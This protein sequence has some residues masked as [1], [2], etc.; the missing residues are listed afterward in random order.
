MATFAEQA[1]AVST[2][3]GYRS[4]FHIFVTW[5]EASGVPSLPASPAD[6]A[7]FLSAEAMRGV[8]V[9]TLGCR[10]AAIR[11]AHKLA[12]FEPPTASEVVRTVLAGIR[13]TVGTAVDRKAAATHDVLGAMLRHIPDTLTGRRD[14]ALLTLGFAA[15]L[16]RSELVALR[17]ED[18]QPDDDGFRVLIRKS[19]TDQEGA[20]QRIAVPHGSHLRPVGAVYDWLATAQISEGPI[21]RPIAKG[22]R[23]LATALTDRSVATI[24]KR[25]AS[26]AGLDPA[27][28][29]GHSLRSGF[30]TSAAKTGALVHKMQAVSR[31]KTVNILFDYVRDADAYKDHAGKEFL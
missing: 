19:K 18:L 24:V 29:S 10:I 11:Y 20:G 14:R 9:S 21:F 28:Y 23:I 16:R 7:T 8:K 26:A 4:D 3:K 13:R 6:V 2:R 15:A 17:V 25:Y 1:K 27:I 30:I 22:G 12:G 5:C 31:H